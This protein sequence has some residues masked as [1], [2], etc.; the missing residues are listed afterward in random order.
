MSKSD[1]QKTKDYLKKAKETG[2]IPVKVMVPA[3]YREMLMELAED[4]RKI[5]KNNL[6]SDLGQ[7]I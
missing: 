6:D 7:Q 5:M 2:L 4:M 3:K 1:V